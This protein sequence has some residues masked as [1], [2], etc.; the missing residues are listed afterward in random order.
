MSCS[1]NQIN[2]DSILIKKINQHPY[3]EDHNRQLIVKKNKFFKIKIELYSDNGEGCSTY[4]SENDSTFIIV[5]CNGRW[6]SIDKNNG[7]ILNLGW[8]WKE[9]LP[10]KFVGVFKSQKNKEFYFLSNEIEEIYKYK[11]PIIE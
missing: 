6:Y 7:S 4:L 9:E 1:N 3:L 11:D 5:D 2:K 10:Q 8:H